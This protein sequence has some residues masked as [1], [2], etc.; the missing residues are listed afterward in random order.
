MPYLSA[1]D[2]SIFIGLTVIC[3]I[4]LDACDIC[5]QNKLDFAHTSTLAFAHT[6]TNS[7]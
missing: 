1:T 7:K 6:L 4:C 2:K 3:F 5:S